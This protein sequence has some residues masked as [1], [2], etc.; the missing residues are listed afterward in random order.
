MPN[1]TRFSNKASL[2]SLFKEMFVN[3]KS[4][5][6]L[7]NQAFIMAGARI[8]GMAFGAV[9]LIWAARC[10]GPKNLGISSMVSTIALQ[11]AMLLGFIN[12]T[13]LVREYK[14]CSKDMER[15]S[16]IRISATYRM[17]AGIM[18]A[19][20]GGIVM[21]AGILPS[22]YHFAGWFFIPLVLIASAQPA[23][24]YQAAEKQHFQSSIAVLQPALAAI[25]YL[26]LFRPGMSAGSD[27]A[28]TTAVSLVVLII[29]WIFIY[30]LTPLRGTPLVWGDFKQAAALAWESRWLF[31][32]T[33][34]IYV[35]T[36]LEQPLLGWL[37]SLEELG[38][39][40]TA[41][42]IVTAAQ[43]LL[44]IIPMLLYPRFLEWRKQSEEL[45]WSRQCKLAIAFAALG[46]V[47]IIGAFL[48]MP[49][50]HPLL[51]GNAF[52]GAAIPGAILIVSKMVVI[53]NGIYGWGL[54]TDKYYDKRVSLSMLGA[55]VL[56]VTLN[57]ALIPKY[58]MY[59]A[60]CVNVVCETLLLGVFLH[61]GMKRIYNYRGK[62]VPR[63]SESIV[64]ME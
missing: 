31:I 12:Q 57:V 39:Y 21:S 35:Y 6:R 42:T 15:S 36:T 8:V 3:L 44:G 46:V 2:I 58:G 54:M 10:L 16:L 53:V 45:L 4:K 59:A 50:I 48:L 34:A 7:L 19:I 29:Y 56:S 9:G 52:A 23:W 47:G 18:F 25:M 28:V 30:R 61:L 22:D 32:S 13:V 41:V 26:I 55:A 33:L 40:R 51:F 63:P 64:Y 11:A 49:I 37:Y 17:L 20:V 24:V 14:N 27:L 60:A 43:G 62:S 5:K 38:K 1:N